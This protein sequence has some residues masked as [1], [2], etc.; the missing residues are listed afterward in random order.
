MA[1]WAVSLGTAG[2]ILVNVM[3]LSVRLFARSQGLNVRWWSRS[4]APERSHLRMLARSDDP[5]IALRARRYL[6]LEVATW[7]LFVLFAIVFFWGVANR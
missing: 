4:F 6:R 3:L 2:V 1:S 5:V 7:V